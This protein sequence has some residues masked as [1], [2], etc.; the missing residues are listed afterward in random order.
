MKINYTVSSTGCTGSARVIFEIA[1]RLIERGHD[2]TITS[3]FG[4]GDE[5]RWF[6]LKTVVHYVNKKHFL[7]INYSLKKLFRRELDF[8]RP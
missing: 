3:C 4:S 7:G 8:L 5:H 6:P 1:N 2:V